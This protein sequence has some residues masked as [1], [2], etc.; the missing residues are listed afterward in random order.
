[1]DHME[2]VHRTEFLGAEFLTWLWYRSDVQDGMF[3]GGDEVGPFEVWF[4]DKLVVKSEI[5]DAQENIF[6]GG[7]P[8]SSQEARTALRLGKLASEARLRVVRGAQ[9]WSFGIKGKTL[10]LSGLKL[11]AVLSREDDEKFYERMLLVEQ[12]EAMMQSL[13][14]TFARLRTGDAWEADE[15]PAIRRWI[16][17]E[18]GA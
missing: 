2:L 16:E 3:H 12:V 11:P 4:D 13:Y 9:E 1:M 15:L 6:K 14:T 18:E 5:A 7:H 17:S 8:T 10:A